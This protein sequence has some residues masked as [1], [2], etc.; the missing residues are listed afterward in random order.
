MA[1]VISNSSLSS[2][3]DPYGIMGRVNKSV[4][5]GGFP[6]VAD[7]VNALSLLVCKFYSLYISLIKDEQKPVIEQIAQRRA[8][9]AT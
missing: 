3:K 2:K 8:T 4:E 5:S 6:S 9:P 7:S 1:R